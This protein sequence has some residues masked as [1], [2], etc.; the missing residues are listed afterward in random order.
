MELEEL[1]EK[2]IETIKTY[3]PLIDMNRM[4]IKKLETDKKYAE[5]LG[6]MTAAL[7]FEKKLI[8]ARAEMLGYLDAQA[9]LKSLLK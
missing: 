3:D 4:R 6:D 5:E 9:R 8:K 1:K 7:D 2:I